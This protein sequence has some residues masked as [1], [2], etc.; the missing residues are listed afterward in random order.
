MT[1]PISDYPHW[2]AVDQPW[3]PRRLHLPD[4]PT[5]ATRGLLREPMGSEH[6]LPRCQKCL[7]YL[8]REAGR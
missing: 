7:A 1:N 4:G 6:R 3:K 5:K 2:M 8:A